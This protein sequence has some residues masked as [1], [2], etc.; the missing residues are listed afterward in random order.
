MSDVK[1]RVIHSI[2]LGGNTF[3][4]TTM[5]LQ[6]HVAM[7]IPI[8]ENNTSNVQLFCTVIHTHTQTRKR[9]ILVH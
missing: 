6:L 5:Q 2:S 3:S 4:K 1:R 7:G 9:V 8:M